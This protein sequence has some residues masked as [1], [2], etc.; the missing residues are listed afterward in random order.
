MRWLPAV[1]LAMLV[2][3]DDAPTDVPVQDAAPDRGGAHDGQ[4]VPDAALDGPIPDAHV[5]AALMAPDAADADPGDLHV[6]A[7]SGDSVVD[8]AVSDVHIEPDSGDSAPD[9]EVSDVRVEPDAGDSAPDVE[10]R[11]VQVEADSGDSAVD[12]DVSDVLI[13]PD[14]AAPDVSECAGAETRECPDAPCPGGTQSCVAGFWAPCVYPVEVC[15]GEDNDCDEAV[16]EG[17]GGGPL[18][19]VCYDG[20]DDTVGVGVCRAG[21]AQC[22]GGEWGGCAGQVRPAADEVCNGRDDDCDGEIDDAEGTGVA[23]EDGVGGCR[24]EGVTACDARTGEVVCTATAGVPER[25][26]CNDIDDDCDGDVDNVIRLGAPCFAGSG[27]CRRQGR[28]ECGDGP[29]LV[30]DAVPA[31][32][33]AEVCDGVD[34][35]CDGEVDDVEGLGVACVAGEGACVREGARVC[36]AGAAPVC[37]AE[38]G[39]PVGEICNGIDDDCDGEADNLGG[40]CTVGRGSC[41]RVGVRDCADAVEVCVELGP[42]ADAEACAGPGCDGEVGS[43][44]V[45]DACGVCGGDGGGCA[46]DNPLAAVDG[47]VLWLQADRLYDVELGDRPVAE[48]P[49]VAELPDAVQGQVG[50]QPGLVQN[51]L[52][53]HSAL[54]FDGDDR[55]DLS[56]NLFARGGNKTLFVVL[57]TE[58]DSA[59]VL[60]AQESGGGQLT[61]YGHNVGVSAGGAFVKV[62]DNGR[63]PIGFGPRP[64]NDGA[65]HVVSAYMF[66]GGTQLFLDGL[67]GPI[68]MT[69]FDDRSYSRSSIGAGNGQNNNGQSE[70]FVGDLAEIVVYDGRLEDAQREAIEAWLAAQYGVELA[71]PFGCD[72]EVR[73]ALVY[74]ACGVCDGDGESCP[75]EDV[76][77][78]GPVMWLRA[79]DLHATHGDGQLV[80]FWPDVGGAAHARQPDLVRAPTFHRDV[81]GEHAVVRFTDDRLDIDVNYFPS[82]ALERSVF[83]VIATEDDAGHIVGTNDSGNGYLTRYG[84]GLA[85]SD[86]APFVRIRNNSRGPL[87]SA[88]RATNDGTPHIV[89]GVARRFETTLHINGHEEARGYDDTN[90][91]RYSRS[92]IGAGNGANNNGMA[93]IWNGDIAELM[94]FDR[95]LTDEERRAVERYL[96]ARYGVALEGPRDCHDVLDG[97]ARLDPCGV[98]EGD[99]STCEAAA[100]TDAGPWTWLRAR[101]L[102]AR[103]DQRVSFWPDQSGNGNHARSQDGRR[104]FFDADGAGEHPALRFEDIQRMDLVRNLFPDGALERSFFVVLAT[105]DTDAHVVGTGDSGNG[106]LTRYGSAVAMVGGSPYV[107]VLDNSRGLGLS[108][109]VDSADGAT[110]VVS[111]VARNGRSTIHVDGLRGGITFGGTD[112]YRYTVTTIGAGNGSNNNGLADVFNGRV[113]EVILFDRAVE[114]EERAAIDAYLRAAY[115]VAAA[116]PLGCDGEARSGERFDVCGTCGGGGEACDGTVVTGDPELEERPPVLWLRA[117]DLSAHVAEQPVGEW[118]DASPSGNHARIGQR[119]HS[120]LY[121]PDRFNGRPAVRFLGDQRMDLLADVFPNGGFPRTVFVVMSTEE[122][123]DALVIGRGASSNGYLTRYGDGVILL[124]GAPALEAVNNSNGLVSSSGRDIRGGGATLVTGVLETGNT[125]LWVQGRQAAHHLGR[126]NPYPQYRSTI[127]ASD[128]SRSGARA[129]PL[130]GDIAEIIVFDE[131]VSEVRRLAIERYLGEKYG[132]PREGPADCE[133]AID[134]DLALDPCGVCGGDGTSCNAPAVEALEPALW[135]RPEALTHKRDGER[136]HVWRDASGNQTDARQSVSERSPIYRADRFDGRPGVEFAGGQRLDL[137]DNLFGRDRFPLSVFVMMRTE[138]ASAHIIG[139]NAS[140]NGYLHRYGGGLQMSGGRPWLIAVNNNNGLQMQG[141]VQIDHGAPVVVGGVLQGGRSLLRTECRTAARADS[142]LNAYQYPN[143]AIGAGDGS[144]SGALAEPLVGDI[145]EILVFSRALDDGARLAVEDYLGRKYGSLA[146]RDRGDL[147]PEE[148]LLDALLFWPLDEEGDGPRIDAGA[149][150]Q[151][152]LPAPEGLFPE[153]VEGV[154]GGA[155]RFDGTQY[156]WR[157]VPPGGGH[158]GESFTLT[159]WVRLDD[160]AS[161]QTVIGKWTRGASSEREFLLWYNADSETFELRVSDDGGEGPFATAAVRHPALVESGTWYFLEAWFDHVGDT[162]ALRVSNGGEIG[163]AASVEYG[164]G[165]HQGDASLM[166]GAHHDGGVARLRGTLDAVGLWTRL[167]RAEELALLRGGLELD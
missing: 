125:D 43:G 136:V 132:I 23:C 101:D 1:A 86:G 2:A 44:L 31:P 40:E 48:W 46:A 104:P 66:N 51:G 116:G 137:R 93:E 112:S 78:L 63:G 118:V 107:K 126:P 154:A 102:P 68:D 61:R 105:E 8:A 4:I 28:L 36:G 30:C 141:G 35:D 127:G 21:R 60:G 52:N 114:D 167:L 88:D 98:C 160:I 140:A 79:D 94:I 99:G 87:V 38:V 158:G 152:L 56:A 90:S 75:V 69:S 16:D 130:V 12:A 42:E 165:I 59:H 150:G 11:D 145:A 32:G 6:E 108:S 71:G 139:T 18:V 89:S 50:Q 159:A 143:S 147:P 20:P 54:R 45:F 113:A 49:G 153:A 55:L 111:A 81:I 163:E 122:D 96:S 29:E 53:G 103:D 26:V 47:M 138:D 148:A 120:P 164:R 77:A 22:V 91:Y 70:A 76:D 64:M 3:C 10:V 7:D 121:V 25:E 106:Y 73:T 123:T 17:A 33:A 5:D 155:Q 19:R 133:G 57:R 92:T 14:A 151:D 9:G 97:A 117:H 109:G 58:D 65:V 82:G 72:G 161:S 15:D 129:D 37:S 162:L 166:L 146:C 95:A 142:Q 41:L 128:G 110:H 131:R 157:D 84:S 13:E 62:R 34:N 144:G 149:G 83:A 24:R 135:L 80:S 74:D 156:L 27:P 119:A 100:V 124:G 115:G 39:A 67:P 134:G 85:S